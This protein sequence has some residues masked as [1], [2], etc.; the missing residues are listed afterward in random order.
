MIKKIRRIIIC[1]KYFLKK[2][3]RLTQTAIINLKLDFMILKFL[4]TICKE[5]TGRKLIHVF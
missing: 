1:L 4:F 5:I 2:K 3:K